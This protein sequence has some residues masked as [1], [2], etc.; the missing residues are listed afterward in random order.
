LRPLRYKGA[1]PRAAD[2]S[3]YDRLTP[4]A[5]FDVICWFRLFIA[6]LRFVVA[7]VASHKGRGFYARA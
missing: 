3:R 5:V 6:A 7:R 2:V 1:P 4:S